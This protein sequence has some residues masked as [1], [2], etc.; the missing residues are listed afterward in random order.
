[1]FFVDFKGLKV[2]D[3]LVLRKQLKQANAKL[4]VTK[5]TLLQ[6]VFTEKVIGIDLKK[7]GGEIATVFAYADPIPAVKMAYQFAKTNANLKVVGGYLDS[8]MYEADVLKEIANLPSKEQLLGRLVG[9]IA[10]P[11]SGFMNVLQGNTKGLIMALSAMS[12]K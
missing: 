1:M 9:S 12:K 11:I 5:K 2:K 3:L 8:K 6:K 10:S 4:Q 7:L